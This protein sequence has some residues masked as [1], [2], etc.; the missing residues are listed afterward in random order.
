MTEQGADSSAM[1]SDEDSTA[2]LDL[3]EEL[4]L[5][6]AWQME[7]RTLVRFGACCRMLSKLVLRDEAYAW[8]AALEQADPA[9]RGVRLSAQRHIGHRLVCPGASCG[10]SWRDCFLVSLRYQGELLEPSKW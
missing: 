4:L 2:L 7:P 8:A 10:G 5:L 6:I 3:S 9:A 1:A